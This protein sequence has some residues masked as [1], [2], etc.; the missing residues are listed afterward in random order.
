MRP[1]DF[2]FGDFQ[3]VPIKE[4]RLIQLRHLADRKTQYDEP[5]GGIVLFTVAPDP[6][7]NDLTWL[8]AEEQGKLSR[9]TG[10]TFFDGTDQAAAS[11]MINQ[12]GTELA[13]WLLVLVL[14]LLVGEILFTRWL[15]LRRDMLPKPTGVYA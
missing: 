6:A 1:G 15:S 9:E 12:P 5:T 3:T 10:V 14:A 11:L 8:S 4:Q 2:D 7:E 13:G